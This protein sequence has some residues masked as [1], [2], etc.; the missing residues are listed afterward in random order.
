MPDD[1]YATLD[2][3]LAGRLDPSPLIGERV[4]LE[5]LADAIDRARRPDAPVRILYVAD[6]A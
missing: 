1:W 4:P 5:G 3:V 2:L 6:P